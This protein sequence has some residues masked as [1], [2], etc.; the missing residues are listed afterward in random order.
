MTDY[1]REIVLKQLGA[2][3]SVLEGIIGFISGAPFDKD[4][5]EAPEPFSTYACPECKWVYSE[6]TGCMKNG[7]VSQVEE[8]EPGTRFDS[9][10]PGWTCPVCGTAPYRFEKSPITDV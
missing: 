10:P 2:V 4:V 3:V 7:A 5:E 9:L 8:A 1:E 6:E